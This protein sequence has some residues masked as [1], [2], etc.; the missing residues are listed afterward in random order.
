MPKRSSTVAPSGASG[1]R[2]SSK[3]ADIKAHLLWYNNNEAQAKV[4]YEKAQSGV[5][6]SPKD[7]DFMSWWAG[8][9]TANPDPKTPPRFSPSVIRRDA[10]PM[11]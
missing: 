8:Y 9:S 2:T 7:R 4:L 10:D 5:E 3:K 11:K 6:L 1:A